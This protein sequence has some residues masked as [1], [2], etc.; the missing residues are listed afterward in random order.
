MGMLLD[1]NPVRSEEKLR[2]F[3]A[4]RRQQTVKDTASQVKKL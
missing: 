2:V 1:S 4:F 3:G